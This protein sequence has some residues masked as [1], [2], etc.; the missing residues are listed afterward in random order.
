MFRS[1]GAATTPGTSPTP[2]PDGAG[3]AGTSPTPAPGGAGETPGVPATAASNETV[4]HTLGGLSVYLSNMP[5]NVDTGCP[6]EGT[7]DLDNRLCGET[8]RTIANKTG[9]DPDSG[10]L[11]L[12]CPWNTHVGFSVESSPPSSPSNPLI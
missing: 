2:A 8:N 12:E 10:V 6:A 7:T 9:W 1:G 3:A 4:N 11:S 5:C